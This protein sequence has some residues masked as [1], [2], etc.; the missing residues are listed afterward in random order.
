[1]K[2]HLILPALFVMM[3]GM[4]L[5]NSEALQTRSN[6]QKPASSGEKQ[7]SLLDGKYGSYFSLFDFF[8][9]TLPNDTIHK[10]STPAVEQSRGKQS[11]G[12]G[13]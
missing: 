11:S 2:K 10:P 5:A 13:K 6:D 3:S 12:K 1:M 8:L 9:V 7:T 4:A